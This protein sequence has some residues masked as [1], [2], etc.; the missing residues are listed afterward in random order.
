MIAHSQRINGRLRI[1]GHLTLTLTLTAGGGS[2]QL[3]S[4]D[5]GDAQIAL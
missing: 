4:R 3:A 2:D 5:V 1:C